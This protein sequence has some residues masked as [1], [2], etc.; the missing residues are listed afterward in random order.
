M[1]RSKQTTSFSP[2]MLTL[3]RA[4]PKQN[5]AAATAARAFSTVTPDLKVQ[6]AKAKVRQR[7][8]EFGGAVDGA[9]CVLIED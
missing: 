4:L 7:K 2:S 1:N 3:A 6:P 5:A 8:K 9:F